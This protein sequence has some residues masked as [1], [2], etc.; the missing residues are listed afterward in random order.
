MNRWVIWVTHGSMG[1]PGHNL[2]RLQ[3]TDQNS[4]AGDPPSLYLS[5]YIYL[6]IYTQVSNNQ[7]WIVP[8]HSSNRLGRGSLPESLARH[9][10]AA[11]AQVRAGLPESLGEAARSRFAP[12]FAQVR[13]GLPGSL[14]AP[15]QAAFA[16][17]RA[18]PPAS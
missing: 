7:G 9:G 11:R 4:R 13:E 18:T 8:S 10:R 6:F 1:R 5:T 2:V 17:V 3:R 16:Q 14:G 12:A 15:G